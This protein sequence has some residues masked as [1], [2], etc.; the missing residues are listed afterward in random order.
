MEKPH[1]CVL[2]RLQK[3]TYECGD[4]LVVHT[5]WLGEKWDGPRDRFRGWKIY[6]AG[7]SIERR[8]LV[9]AFATR[10]EAYRYVERHVRK[11]P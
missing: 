9:D 8:L 3:G 6:K 11:A 4:Y 10:E 1:K 7:S 5:S 2:K